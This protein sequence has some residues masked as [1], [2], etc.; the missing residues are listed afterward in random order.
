MGNCLFWCRCLWKG[1]LVL[2][3]W[4][5]DLI[6]G[7][8]QIIE[9]TML[10]Q[11][12]I[13]HDLKQCRFV[14]KIKILK[15][16]D[17]PW[18]ESVFCGDLRNAHLYSHNEIFEATSS[19]SESFKYWYWQG[20]VALHLGLCGNVWSYNLPRAYVFYLCPCC[21]SWKPVPE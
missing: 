20:H 21:L 7:R 13:C 6:T 17:D 5:L 4:G 10:P 1:I 16:T 19:T 11:V 14:L 8:K 9:N 2:N 3:P 12:I 18:T 15:L